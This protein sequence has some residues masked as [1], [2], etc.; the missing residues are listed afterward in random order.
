[1]KE[2]EMNTPQ[3]NAPRTGCSSEEK[4]FEETLQDNAC[5]ESVCIMGDFNAQMGKE[6][7][8]RP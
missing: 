7:D 5:G 6:M 4:E 2:K 8:A 3:I 1:M